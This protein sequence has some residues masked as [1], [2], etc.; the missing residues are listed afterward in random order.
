MKIGISLYILILLCFLSPTN[1]WSRDQTL[2]FSVM[3]MST[4]SDYGDGSYS[5]SQRFTAAIGINLTSVTEIELTY[6]TGS[7]TLLN[8]PIQTSQTRERTYGASLIQTL[9]PAS[10]RIQPYVRLGVA[11]YQREQESTYYGVALG[12]STVNDP[13]AM[14]GAGLRLFITSGLSLRV[15]ATGYMPRMDVNAA[16]KNYAVQAGVQVGF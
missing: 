13:S 1:V 14:V 5:R 9:V 2:S 10:W 16:R 6:S 15:E 8:E 3:G 12:R 7:T 4:R 11:Q